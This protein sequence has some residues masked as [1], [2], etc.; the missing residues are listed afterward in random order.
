MDQAHQNGN[1]TVSI[2]TSAEH[3]LSARSSFFPI[4]VIRRSAIRM[5][6]RFVNSG[7]SLQTRNRS[8][9]VTDATNF[10]SDVNVDGTVNSGDSFIVRFEIGNLPAL[11]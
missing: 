10:R 11:V 4:P 6:T 8:G 3:L 2:N 5:A 9:Q 1:F 7:D